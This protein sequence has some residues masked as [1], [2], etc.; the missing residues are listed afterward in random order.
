MRPAQAGA[1]EV[2]NFV[3]VVL[4]QLPNLAGAPCGNLANDVFNLTA[5]FVAG[6]PDDG[7]QFG[8][9]LGLVLFLVPFLPHFLADLAQ[10]AP[11]PAETGDISN[12]P[13]ESPTHTFQ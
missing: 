6:R 7:L 5:I 11:Y 1:N 2:G 3:E 8:P 9:P 10:K 12:M 13:H 4:H